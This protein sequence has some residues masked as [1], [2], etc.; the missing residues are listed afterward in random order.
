MH[1]PTAREGLILLVTSSFFP[2]FPHSWALSPMWN[3][4]QPDPPPPPPQPD[5]DSL[6]PPLLPPQWETGRDW[7]IR[8]PPAPVLS[9]GP[10][11]EVENADGK[12]RRE[13]S[14]RAVKPLHGGPS[15][16]RESPDILVKRREGAAAGGHRAR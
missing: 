13:V 3:G 1:S 5:Q 4:R 2:S 15:K 12:G 11:S 7:G 10:E 14:G 16:R 9:S 8:A 6:T